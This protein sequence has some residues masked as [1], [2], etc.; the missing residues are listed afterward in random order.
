MPTPNL[1]IPG[2]L[3]SD[4]SSLFDYLCQHH[5]IFRSKFKKPHI[6]AFDDRYK[7]RFT[8]Q[9]D[10]NFKKM[11]SKSKTFKFIPD[12]SNIYVISKYGKQLKKCFT[13]FDKNPIFVLSFESL[14]NNFVQTINNIFGFLELEPV[15]IDKA[16]K[17]KTPTHRIIKRKIPTNIKL[18]EKKVGLNLITD[19]LLFNK[20]LKPLVFIEQDGIFIFDLLK[21]NVELLK[22]LN[23]IFPK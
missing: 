8:N 3:K 7:N 17:N 10:F 9:G 12:A 23:L 16:Q 2:F 18:L 19:S 21:N 1:I 15:V 20:K 22:K 14:K 11:Y 5:D 4:T 13:L 6:Y